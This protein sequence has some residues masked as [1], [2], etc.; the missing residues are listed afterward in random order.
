[1]I[2][3]NILVLNAT[4]SLLSGQRFEASRIVEDVWDNGFALDEASELL[5]ANLLLDLGYLGMASRFLE[6]KVYNIDDYFEKYLNI[7]LKFSLLTLDL[8]LLKKIFI[9]LDHNIQ[10]KIESVLSKI[11]LKQ[12][13]KNLQKYIN[14]SNKYLV[15]YIYKYECKISNEKEECLLEIISYVGDEVLDVKEFSERFERYIGVVFSKE[16]LEEMKV[17]SFKIVKS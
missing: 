14:M 9:F 10:I 5:Y 8:D 3:G 13:I 7:F 2:D 15:E 6:D 4:E 16:E 11:D 12:N 1:M 17:V